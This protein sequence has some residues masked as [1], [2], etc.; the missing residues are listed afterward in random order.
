MKPYAESV[1]IP[2]SA[3]VEATQWLYG[4]AGVTAEPSGAATTAAVRCGA[5]QPNGPTVLVVSGGNIDP[6]TIPSLQA[7]A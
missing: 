6:A 2:D 4:E 7:V 1:T 5:F 3:I